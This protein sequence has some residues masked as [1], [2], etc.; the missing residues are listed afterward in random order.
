MKALSDQFKMDIQQ[1]YAQGLPIDLIMKTLNISRGVV[2]KYCGAERRGH[3][4]RWD[5]N[6][7]LLCDYRSKNKSYQKIAN[8]LNC[9]TNAAKIAM[10][11]YRKKTRADPAKRLVTKLVLRA[12]IAGATPGQAIRRVRDSDVIGRMADV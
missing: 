11:R 6:N 3:Y 2:S 1:L 4:L 10:C 5:K 7:Q 8:K 9:T 12:L